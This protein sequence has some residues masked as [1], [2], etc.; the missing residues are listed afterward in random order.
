MSLLTTN[1][2]TSAKLAELVSNVGNHV[3]CAA[4]FTN[5]MVSTLL[6][7]SDD[8]LSSWLNAN[9][10]DLDQIFTDHYIVGTKINEGLIAINS[11]LIA[12]GIPLTPVFV[13][14]SSVADKLA[15]QG[16]QMTF[17]ETGIVIA[18]IPPPE[19]DPL[20]ELPPDGEPLIDPLLEG[21]PPIDPPIEPPID[22]LVEP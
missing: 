21:D 15:V 16:R 13:D 3:V 7:L 6:D 12:A 8:D 2:R 22:P 4:Q 17:T 20:D 9:I 1:S 5:Q 18:P 19:P 14:V 11:Q 10:A